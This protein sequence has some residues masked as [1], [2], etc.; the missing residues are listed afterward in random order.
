MLRN[1]AKGM[2]GGIE[3]FVKRDQKEV[4]KK[5]PRGSSKSVFFRTLTLARGGLQLAHHRGLEG[6]KTL[7]PVRHRKG[8][9]EHCGFIIYVTQ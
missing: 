2:T 6:F 4:R 9:P 3:A 1:E 5:L 8:H 7:R